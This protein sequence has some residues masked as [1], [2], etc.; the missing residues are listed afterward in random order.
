MEPL[1]VIVSTGLEKILADV[2]K[3]ATHVVRDKVK[4]KITSEILYRALSK[5][6]PVQ[7]VRT[8]INPEKISDL[9]EVYVPSAA[10]FSEVDSVENVD[11]FGKK[12]ILI[13][14]VAGSGKSLLMRHLCLKEKK[15]EQY[16]PLFIEFRNL[17]AKI[18]LDEAI[19]SHLSELGIDVDAEIFA[20]LMKSNRIVLLLDGFDEIKSSERN[21][22]ARELESLARAYPEVMVVVSSRPNSG[23]GGSV[24]FHTFPLLPLSKETKEEFVTKLTENKHDREMILDVIFCSDI[25]PEVTATPLMLTLFI[26]TFKARQF[27]PDT[28]AEF[29]SLIFPTM[30]YRHDRMKVGFNRD[31]ES[32]L[33]DFI[34]QKL[35]ETFCFLTQKED[36]LRSDRYKLLKVIE[37][38][39][40][41]EGVANVVPE[42]LL[43]DYL[44]I[45]G[46]LVSDGFET[47]SFAH[48]SIQEFFSA[49]FVSR[50]PEDSKKVFYESLIGN[51]E[52]FTKWR[53]TMFFLSTIDQ[54]SYLRFYLLPTKKRLLGL[55]EGSIADVGYSDMVAVIG[56]DTRVKATEEG[57][58]I[59]IYWDDMV[60]TSDFVKF[61]GAVK[62]NIEAFLRSNKKAL[63]EYLMFCPI[64]DYEN[65]RISDEIFVFNLRSFIESEGLGK[66]M[67]QE[68]NK[69]IFDENIVSEV[70]QLELRVNESLELGLSLVSV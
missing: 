32:G 66:S 25:L 61:S 29:Y 17:D 3:S 43:S 59:S 67:L 21:R 19:V 55:D 50:L 42:S 34:I 44:K 8:V 57:E 38:S 10:V 64:S 39:V 27:K 51:D 28:V 36:V 37:S 70:L 16:I 49:S 6:E 14:A 18:S 63:A 35:F 40:Q 5:L 2:A 65:Y 31:R 11:F 45:T 33:S 12:K 68:I 24:Y 4:E 13:E 46:L 30:L 60:A 7:Q 20:V 48:K 53:N 69:S 58:Y 47:Y 23:L 41:V 52:K 22:M 62:K 15:R 54:T 9:Y 56:Q 26:I 1:G